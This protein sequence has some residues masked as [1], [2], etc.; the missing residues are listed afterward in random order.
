[1]KLPASQ[2]GGGNQAII[3]A[4]ATTGHNLELEIIDGGS[5]Y[6]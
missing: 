5:S 3:L 2:Q 1:M 4:L 6:A